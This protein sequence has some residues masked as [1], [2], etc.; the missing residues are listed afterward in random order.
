MYGT[1]AANAD[2]GKEAT[3]DGFR[4][5]T[6]RRGEVRDGRARRRE[7][8]ERRGCRPERTLRI[9]YHELVRKRRMSDEGSTMR[10]HN[11]TGLGSKT[12]AKTKKQGGR[13]Q[14]CF[15]PGKVFGLEFTDQRREREAQE[16]I[17]DDGIVY[18]VGR[19]T[20]QRLQP[21][22]AVAR[23]TPAGMSDVHMA[24]AG[25]PINPT[26]GTGTKRAYYSAH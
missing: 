22:T 12:T 7:R 11:S 3:E 5:S 24:A 10:E 25:T 6:R 9:P 2:V 19:G 26:V 18:G 4:K 16:R 20:D 13:P 1:S 21:L 8:M 15:Q 17:R 14:F 23:A